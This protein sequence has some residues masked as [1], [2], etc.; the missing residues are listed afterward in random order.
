MIV[1]ALFQEKFNNLRWDVLNEIERAINLAN[2][3]R[4]VLQCSAFGCFSC[5][6]ACRFVIFFVFETLN[7]AVTQVR[8]I[9]L[10]GNGRA[11]CAGF[12]FS[13]ALSQRSS[14]MRIVDL[15]CC[16]LSRSVFQL[17]TPRAWA[18]K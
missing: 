9:V 10:R 6:S 13:A 14:C 7:T 5:F 11:F 8:V 12:D 4:D 15:L 18:T 16:P 2:A 1:F 3:D 17:T